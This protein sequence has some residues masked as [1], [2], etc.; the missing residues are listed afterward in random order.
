MLR[1]LKIV[2]WKAFSERTVHFG[3]GV[4]FLL[5]QNGSG[6]TSILE[7]IALALTGETTTADFHD[8]IRD[9]HRDSSVELAFDLKGVAY[10]VKRS[11]STERIIAAD[12]TV[13]DQPLESRRWETVSSVLSKHLATEPTFFSRLIY[14][15]EGEV[16]QYL[17]EPPREALDNA[18]TRAFGLDKLQ[19]L[20][21][22]FR[23]IQRDKEKLAKSLREDLANSVNV[24]TVADV[25]RIGA[26]LR[27]LEERLD[28]KEKEFQAVLAHRQGLQQ[29]ML[30]IE[31]LR[32]LARDFE[33]TGKRFGYAVRT[34]VPWITETEQTITTARLKVAHL[35][36]D[37]EVAMRSRGSFSSVVNSIERV[38]AILKQVVDKPE[39]GAVPC[40]ICKRPIDRNMAGQLMNETLNELNKTRADLIRAEEQQESLN[41]VLSELRREFELLSNLKVQMD[42][43]TVSHE[44]IPLPDFTLNDLV[45]VLDSRASILDAANKS[46]ENTGNVIAELK[47]RIATTMADLG[48][49]RALAGPSSA[50][51][52]L[53]RRL[54]ETYTAAIASSVAER[55]LS[56]VGH[57]QRNL[58]LEPLYKNLASI[59]E[60]LRPGQ[61][62]QVRFDTKGSLE[63]GR[64]GVWMNY[65]QLSGGEKTVLLVLARVLIC[66]MFSNV[67]FLM[68]DE[69]LEHL[70][71]RNRR[72]L[73]NFLV[74]A[75]SAGLISQVLVTTFEESL[76]R[77]YIESQ[78]V[79]ATYLRPPST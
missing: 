5:G 49:A 18:L 66:A 37:V 12:L 19:V 42:S 21:E 11:F 28:T 43:I 65:A 79:H 36:E 59:W 17:K 71:I 58:S 22:Q 70:D 27:D 53:S 40:P 45:S 74:A 4:N 41:S 77:K 75:A 34:D 54:I 67:D 9:R 63:L 31:R 46:Q 78:G 32:N 44:L 38:T 25:G 23:R 68:I 48:Q 56:D 55:A 2:N 47:D 3:A 51:D 35:A 24:P 6:K 8:L 14:M 57:Q 64:E 69:P 10:A 15:P 76:V 60:Q 13:D 52:L 1:T 61:A 7:A 16:F 72:S 62:Y 26:E 29:Q 20:T 39:P 50:R 30:D 73:I 33:A